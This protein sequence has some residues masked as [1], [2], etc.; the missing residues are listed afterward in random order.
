MA[1]SENNSWR[2]DIFRQLRHRNRTQTEFFQDLVAC[3]NKL[4]DNADALR[5]EN[6]QLSLQNERLR[7]ESV[8]LANTSAA[9]NT[10][11]SIDSRLNERIQHLEQKLLAQQEELTELHRRKGENAQQIIDLNVKL[12]EKEKLLASKEVG[13]ADSTATI[14]SLRAEI[15]MYE[16]SIK[17]LENLNQTIRDEHQALQLAFASLEDKLRKAQEENRQLLERLIHYK[18][19]DAEKMNEE[20]DNFLKKKHAKVQKELEE[21][22]KDMKGIAM[23]DPSDVPIFQSALPK[24][25]CVKFDAHEGEVNAVK[26]GPDHHIVATG[27]ADRKVQLWDIS[28]GS[29]KSRG[30]L[31]GSNASVMSVDFDSTGTLLLG[32]SN[33]F[34]SRVWSV[35]DLRLR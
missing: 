22:C 25:V 7:L 28:K 31:V 13:L 26:W 12:Q 30:V 11:T 32:A 33:D 21:A 23:D 5:S 9:G 3:H 10:T 35:A 1:V 2:D 27:G 16:N 4:F 18:T 15:R 20:N 29:Y 24:Q 8:S 19:K 14:T 34:A 6:L 17:E